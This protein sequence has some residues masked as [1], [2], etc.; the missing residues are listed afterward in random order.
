[1]PV[2]MGSKRYSRRW[3]SQIALGHSQI[4]SEMT[5]TLTPS[6]G[7]VHVVLDSTG[8]KVYGAGEWQREKHGG[9]SRR[10]WRKLHLA[11]QKGEARIAYA[12][13]NRTTE[14]GMPM[15]QRVR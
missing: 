9:R 7:P 3:H 8:L 2:C 4:I 11:A 10:T 6:S 14:L 1:M 5:T 15:S 13:V 12:V